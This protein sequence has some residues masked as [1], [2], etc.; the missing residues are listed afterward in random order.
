LA[1]LAESD[2]I[3]PFLTRF[4]YAADEE[5]REVTSLMRRVAKT[6]LSQLSL[7]RLSAFLALTLLATACTNGFSASSGGNGGSGS[8][9]IVDLD[10]TL[11]APV[12][13]PYGESGGINPPVLAVKTGDTIAFVNSDGFTHTSTSIGSVQTFPSASPIKGIALHQKGAMLSGGWTSGALPAGSGSQTIL[14][15]KPGTYL[16][17]CFFHYGAPMRGAIVAR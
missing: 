16:Y 1:A 13:T 2:T 8:I 15:D 9:Q 11:N 6:R 5:D 3:Q 17:G 10:L 7:A 12:S 14:A 4:H